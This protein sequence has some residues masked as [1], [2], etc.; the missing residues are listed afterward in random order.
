MAAADQMKAVQ[1]QAK[2]LVRTRN[3]IT[4]VSAKKFAQNII[5][6]AWTNTAR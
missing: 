6:V 5:V 4:K 2:E 3:F 1:I